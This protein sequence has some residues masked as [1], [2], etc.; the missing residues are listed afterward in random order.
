MHGNWAVG[1]EICPYQKMHSQTSA[2][3]NY[4]AQYY[5]LETLH[6]S[7]YDIIISPGNHEF[8]TGIRESVRSSNRDLG[9]TPHEA[10]DNISDIMLD[11]LNLTVLWHLPQRWA[12]IV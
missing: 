11:A 6:L 1:R 8:E 9:S 3:W 12:S 4:A 5:L 2:V 7:A 10:F